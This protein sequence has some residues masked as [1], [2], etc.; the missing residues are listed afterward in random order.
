M[1]ALQKT[2]A[3]AIAPVIVF[4]C[5]GAACSRPVGVQGDDAHAQ[6]DATQV[7]FQNGEPSEAVPEPL[8]SDR[9]STA[10]SG[11]DLP[12]RDGESLPVGTLLTVRLDNS[13]STDAPQSGVFEAVVEDPIAIGGNTLVPRGAKVA[14]RIESAR[15]STVKKNRNY[16]RLTL[17][18]LDLEGKE[19]SL[20][21]SSLF[22]Q[23]QASGVTA[24][25]ASTDNTVIYLERGRRLTFRLTEPVYVALQQPPSVR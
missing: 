10:T 22:A 18:S 16:V 2:R 25:G 17:N 24:S 4:L 20:Q 3:R 13:V 15:A 9:S 19:F 5:L 23:G 14:G 1:T 21:T 6:T 7:P 8:T 11:K 12:F